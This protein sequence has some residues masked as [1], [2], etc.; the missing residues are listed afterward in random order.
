MDNK[1]MELAIAL[2]QAIKED[3]RIK[4]MEAAKAAFDSDKEIQSL[5]LEYNTQ[6]VALGE[7]YK[8][9]TQD[10]EFIEVINKRIDELYN[11]I[12]SNEVFIAYNATQD[13]VNKFMNEVNG[14]ITFQITGE[15]P[16]THD[17]SSC[18][19]DCGHHHH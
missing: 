11:S 8:K 10:K 1:V 19:S 15:R 3:E 4:K 16:C 12:V 5:I 18:H 13:E 9:D 2:G 6:R 7:E 17:C 14:E